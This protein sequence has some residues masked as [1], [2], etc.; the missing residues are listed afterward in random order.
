MR[1]RLKS[2]TTP[3]S[4]LTATSSRS[5]QHRVTPRHGT[6]FDRPP[7]LHEALNLSVPS[8]HH[9]LIQPKLMIGAVGDKYEQE[10]DRVAAQVVN[11]INAPQASQPGETIQRRP[12]DEDDDDRLQMKPLFQS[13][14]AGIPATPELAAGIGRSR[15]GGM[16]LTETIRK[17]MEQAFEADFSRVKV[18]TDARADQL[19]RSIHARAFTTQQDIFFRQGEY[20]PG[21]RSGQELI[22]HELTHVVQK[23]GNP[24]TAVI[25]RAPFPNEEAKFRTDNGDPNIANSEYLIDPHGYTRYAPINKY[26]LPSQV[27]HSGKRTFMYFRSYEAAVGFNRYFSKRTVIGEKVGNDIQFQYFSLTH[28]TWL[29]IPEAFWAKWSPAEKM[30]VFDCDMDDDGNI[31]QRGSHFGHPVEDLNVKLP[32]LDTPTRLKELRKLQE[33]LD[34]IIATGQLG[35]DLSSGPFTEQQLFNAWERAHRTKNVTQVEWQTYLKY[36]DY[37]NALFGALEGELRENWQFWGMNR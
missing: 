30:T 8:T 20:Q 16:P 14:S 27:F 22:A 35:A 13:P 10:A 4:T 36:V 12:T 37:I 23:S 21:N 24:F 31:Q 28:D 17:P 5:L 26:R 3:Q 19:N 7:I 15:G 25:Q 18:H 6:A 33:W 32:N 1:S 9:L 29:P 34:Q 11:H 2:Q